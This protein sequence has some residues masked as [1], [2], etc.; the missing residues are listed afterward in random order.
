M[1]REQDVEAELARIAKIYQQEKIAREKSYDMHGG[2]NPSPTEEAM[3]Q[4]IAQ[5]GTP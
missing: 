4:I 3:P 2:D 5:F 1:A